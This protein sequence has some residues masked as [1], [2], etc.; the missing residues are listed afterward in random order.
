MGT[1]TF[2]QKKKYKNAIKNDVY[3]SK[4]TNEYLV[5]SYSILKEVYNRV[6]LPL[7]SILFFE[8]AL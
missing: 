2:K 5:E 3:V 4:L 8:N 6:K 1:N 7:S